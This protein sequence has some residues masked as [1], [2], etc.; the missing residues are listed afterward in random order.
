MNR[1]SWR[2]GFNRRRSHSSG[3]V[4]YRVLELTVGHASVRYGALVAKP[5]KTTHSGPENGVTRR[6]STAHEPLNGDEHPD[7][8]NSAQMNTRI[9]AN[10]TDVPHFSI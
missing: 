2:S 7:L 9:Q 10:E 6:R 3:L 4:F 5:N 1:R 8:L